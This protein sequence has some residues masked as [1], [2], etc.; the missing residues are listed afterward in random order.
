MEE[1]L[2]PAVTSGVAAGVLTIPGTS[3]D[4][5]AGEEKRTQLVLISDKN[6]LRPL[7]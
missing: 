4:T 6:K 1:R 7:F 5:I 3:N 2:A